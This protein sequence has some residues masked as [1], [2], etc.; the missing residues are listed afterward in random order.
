MSS[1]HCWLLLLGIGLHHLLFTSAVI[2]NNHKVGWSRPGDNYNEAIQP[3]QVHLSWDG[4]A[5]HMTV[6]W[7]TPDRCDSVVQYGLQPDNF[8]EKQQGGVSKFMDTGDG[9]RTQYVHRAVMLNLQQRTAYYYRVG[10]GEV[11]SKVFNFTSLKDGSDWSPKL[12]IFGDMGLVN[13]RSMKRLTKDVRLGRLDMI[14]HVGDFAYDMNEDEGRVGDAFM[15][16]IEPL[17]AHVPYQTAVGNHEYWANFTQYKNRFSMPGSENG[18]MY[19]FA[20]GPANFVVFSTEFYFWLQFGFLQIRR[21]YS[22]LRKELASLNELQTRE[23]APWIITLGHRP[24][25]STTTAMTA[26]SMKVSF[27]PVFPSYTRILWRSCFMAQAWICA[28]GPTSTVTNGYGQFT[29]GKSS[30]ARTWPTPTRTL[31]RLCT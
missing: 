20:V 11:W 14:I 18:L 28:Y 5:S 6:T 8:T 10:N 1:F 30:T 2:V 13:A 17:A 23:K 26:Q 21:Q 4:D 12:A 16:M 22:W 7:N 29:T 19:R 27:G 25:Y 31:M 9:H 3:E 24:M 15:R